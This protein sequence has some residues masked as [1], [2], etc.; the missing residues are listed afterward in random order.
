MVILSQLI[1]NTYPQTAC[2]VSYN[3]QSEELR[4]HYLRAPSMPKASHPLLAM[5]KTLNAA[6]ITL[7][8]ASHRDTHTVRR[9][10]LQKTDL[11]L[12]NNPDG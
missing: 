9:G 12:P 2:H 8:A 5:A 1:S 3:R 10:R 11:S 6:T 4:V 7:V